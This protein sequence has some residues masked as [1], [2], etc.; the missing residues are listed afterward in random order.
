MDEQKRD[1]LS[2]LLENG[3]SSETI[4]RYL[5]Q[6]ISMDEL[7]SSCLRFWSVAGALRTQIWKIS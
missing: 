3:M 5:D 7:V 6:G 4:K 2:F 1:G